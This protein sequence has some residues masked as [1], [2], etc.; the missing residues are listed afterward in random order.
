[1]D[2][3]IIIF[4]ILISYIIGNLFT[5]QWVVGITSSL[6]AS[7]IIILYQSPKLKEYQDNIEMF[8]IFIRVNLCQIKPFLACSIDNRFKLLDN[9]F[10]TD[11]GINFYD[12]ESKTH[13]ISG[14]IGYTRNHFLCLSNAIEKCIGNSVPDEYLLYKIAIDDN[15]FIFVGNDINLFQSYDYLQNN[16]TEL[17]IKEK[18]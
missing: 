12:F 15:K 6:I 13:L 10:I 3:R 8:K 16:A 11:L 1:M 5:T 9:Y 17:K 2:K 18:L 7:G 14:T 4:I